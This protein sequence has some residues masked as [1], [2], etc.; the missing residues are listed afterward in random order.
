MKHKQISEKKRLEYLKKYPIGIEYRIQGQEVTR[1]RYIK[2]SELR[3][4]FFDWI[5]REKEYIYEA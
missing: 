5:L 1:D 2:F 3:E 4:S